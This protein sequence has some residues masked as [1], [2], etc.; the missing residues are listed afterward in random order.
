[1]GCGGQVEGGGVGGVWGTGGGVG[2][3]SGV[4]GVGGTGGGG[5]RWKVG[6]R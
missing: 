3:R 6:G 4:G 5:D 2:R 1:M